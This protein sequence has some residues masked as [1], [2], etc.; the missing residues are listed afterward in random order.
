MWHQFYFQIFNYVFSAS[1]KNR[2]IVRLP[3]GRE[4]MFG[5]VSAAPVHIH[6]LN[7][8]FFKRVIRD[9]GIGLG[10]SYTEGLWT[11]SQL[12]PFLNFLVENKVYF[13]E[14]LKYF[15]GIGHALNAAL[16][17]SRKNTPENSVKNI[18]EHYDLSNDFFALFL[19]PSMMYSC[20]VFDD[21]ATT[22][23]QAQSNKIRGLAEKIEI[24]SSD[25]VL[26]IGCGWGAFAIET[27]RR[28][29]CRWTGLTLSQEQKKWAEQK[30]LEAGLQDK[31]QI[32]LTDYRH[33][34]GLYDKIVSV[35]MIEAVGHEYL[36]LFFECCS[37]FLKPGGKMALQSIVIPHDR[38]DSYRKSCDWIQKHIF[39]GG[40]LPSIEVIAHHCG[41][42]GLAI[43]DIA[44]SLGLNYARTLSIWCRNLLANQTRLLEMGFDQSFIRK[45]QYYFCYCESGFLSGMIDNVQIFLEKRG[46]AQ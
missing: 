24:K 2:L 5:D 28:T 46:A 6:V 32:Q 44:P 36:N 21:S 39:P 25:H 34:Q 29:G 7:W 27:V 41:H 42:A 35:E 1:R 14:R 37:Q 10:E 23:E 43:N 13:D 9:T 33:A 8:S 19:D 45:W 3:D 40:H 17:R 26:E 38:Y 30:I 15:K 20:A 12:T 16:H 22:L 11:T 4:R 18:Q 31:I